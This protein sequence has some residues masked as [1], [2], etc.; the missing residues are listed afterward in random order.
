MPSIPEL[1]ED[2]SWGPAPEAPGRANAWLDAHARRF[3]HFIGGRFV[4][5]APEEWFDS[6][7]PANGEQASIPRYREVNDYTAR[8]ICRQL[9]I[10]EP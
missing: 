2:M 5:P 8:S 4:P 7:N 6:S 1:F 3:G 10:A 9:G